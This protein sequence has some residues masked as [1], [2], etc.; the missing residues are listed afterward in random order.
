MVAMLNIASFC[1][2]ENIGAV[3]KGEPCKSIKTF[4][5]NLIFSGER[6]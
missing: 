4:L 6:F 1:P 2:K 3:H 5:V